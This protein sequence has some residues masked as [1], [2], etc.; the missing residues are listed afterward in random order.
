VAEADDFDV[1]QSVNTARGAPPP[2]DEAPAAPTIG[3]DERPKT[4]LRLLEVFPF[5]VP[6]EVPAGTPPYEEPV[7]VP[8]PEDAD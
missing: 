6:V 3:P 7:H 4:E 1:N 2:K 8:E 5:V